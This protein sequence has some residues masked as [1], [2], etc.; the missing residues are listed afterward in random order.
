MFLVNGEFFSYIRYVTSP[1]DYTFVGGNTL[2][3]TVERVYYE[4]T[5]LYDGQELRGK[6]QCVIYI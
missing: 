4:F 6:N 3:Y 5:N 1:A 2:D